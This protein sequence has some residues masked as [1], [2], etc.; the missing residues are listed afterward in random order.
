MLVEQ[1]PRMGSLLIFNVSF[2]F[3]Y[4]K[5]SYLLTQH[6]HPLLKTVHSSLKMCESCN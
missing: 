5:P 2:V 6:L 1:R 3:G 4:S